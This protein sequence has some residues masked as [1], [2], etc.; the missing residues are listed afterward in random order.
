[1]SFLLVAVGFGAVVSR[2]WHSG[3]PPV[4]VSSALGVPLWVNWGPLPTWPC[5]PGKSEHAKPGQ[6]HRGSK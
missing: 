6:V 2:W 4:A 1:L 3:G 5:Y